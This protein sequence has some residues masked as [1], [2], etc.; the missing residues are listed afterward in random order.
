MQIR[1]VLILLLLL[2]A[3]SATLYAG[4]VATFVNLGFSDDSETFVFGQYGIED[5]G[6]RPYAEIYTVDVDRNEFV[7]EGVMKKVFEDE[8]TPG[9]D[10]RGALF[11][12]LHGYAP[13]KEKYG[14]NHLATGRI[15]YLL[16]DGKEPKRR[17][18]FRDFYK[19]DTYV[20][21]LVQQQFGEGENVRASFHINLSV[22]GKDGDTRTYTLGLPDYKREGVKSYR[23]NRVFF[24]PNEK[25]L[26][27]VVEKHMWAPEGAR[28]RYMV[29]TLKANS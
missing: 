8:V 14:I 7:Q 24:S 19:G 12:L 16:I 26:V 20:L 1:R 4:D 11:N 17:L 23:I 28:I 6:T 21:T 10:G 5:E 25:G 15:V 22:T 3:A 2:C 27:C 18:E 29:E 9:Q 13:I